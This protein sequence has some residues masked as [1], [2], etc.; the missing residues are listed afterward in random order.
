ME[1]LF[2]SE[3]IIDVKNRL[4]KILISVSTC[5]SPTGTFLMRYIIEPPGVHEDKREEN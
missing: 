1:D 3:F 5:G 2:F 4:L